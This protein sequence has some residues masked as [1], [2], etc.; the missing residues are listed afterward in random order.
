VDSAQ[1]PLA[2]AGVVVLHE[3]RGDAVFTRNVGA[4]GLHKKAAFVA[5]NGGRQKHESVESSLKPL[6]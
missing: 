1:R 4:E 2:G 3:L 6:H 5:V